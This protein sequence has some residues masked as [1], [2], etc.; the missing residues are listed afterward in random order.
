MALVPELP[1]TAA[2][3]AGTGIATVDAGGGAV[4]VP[5]TTALP[6]VSGLLLVSVSDLAGAEVPALAT[7]AVD[8]ACRPLSAVVEEAGADVA[9]VWAITEPEQSKHRD[10][11]KNKTFQNRIFDP[12][13][14]AGR[15]ERRTLDHIVAQF[16][17]SKLQ[18]TG[19]R[20]DF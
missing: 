3:D 7:P 19:N 14:L 1:G 16:A 2:E 6:V 13:V 5:D 17:P 11:P 8:V 18:S 20:K 4:A 10:N 15:I 9:G 12:L